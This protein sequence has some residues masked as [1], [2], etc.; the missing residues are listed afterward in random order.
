MLK[1]IVGDAP[2]TS[3][4]YLARSIGTKTAEIIFRDSAATSSGLIDA[5]STT[6]CGG[7]DAATVAYS[8][9]R[10]EPCA[11]SVMAVMRAGRCGIRAMSLC[12]YTL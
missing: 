2:S 5:R 3:D 11:Y 6:G 7:N 1:G 12:F 10:F 8:G 9:S 4:S